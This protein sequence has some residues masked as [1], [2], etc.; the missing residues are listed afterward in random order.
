MLRIHF[1]LSGSGQSPVEK[2]LGDLPEAEKAEVYAAFQDLRTRG[3]KEALV[4]LRQIEG[5]LWEIRVSQ[6]RVFYVMVEGP[7]MVLLHVYKKQSQKA[8]KREIHLA[9]NRMK[10]VLASQKR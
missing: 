8:P 5:K 3:L 4:S 7:L 2:Y 6:Q 1:Y 10:Q 9:K